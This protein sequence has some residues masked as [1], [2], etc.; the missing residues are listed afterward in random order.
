MKKGSWGIAA[1]CVLWAAAASVVMAQGKP[2]VS[3]NGAC[4]VTVPGDWVQVGSFG[5]ANSADKSMTVAVSSPSM[6]PTLAQVKENAPKLYP[7][8]QVVKDTSSEFQMEGKS[9][10]GKPNVYRGVQLPGKVCLAEVTY[11]SGTVEDARKIVLS[12]GA[13]K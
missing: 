2:V 1:G 3:H 9:G 11:T 7:E 4:Q 12:L 10:N 8:D 13:A 5:I 6:S